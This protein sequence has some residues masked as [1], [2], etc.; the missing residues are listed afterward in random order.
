MRDTFS[1]VTYP[2]Q[3]L[4][5]LP[6]TVGGW[7]EENLATRHALQAENTS[8]RAQNL[9]LNVRLQKLATLESENMRLREL[10]DSSFKINERVLIAE[11]LAVDL[12]PFTRRIIINK[13][14]R[15]G[16]VEGQTLVDA[17]GV[18]GQ[19]VHVGPF[20]STAMLITD[21]SHAVPIQVNRNGLRAILVGTGEPDRLELMHVPN[22]ADIEVGDLLVT[23]GLGGRF[24]PGYPVARVTTFLPD[25]RERFAQVYAEPT[26]SLEQ[27]RE[28]LL[29][30]SSADADAAPGD[31]A[32][33]DTTCDAPSAQPAPAEATT[34]APAAP[35]ATN[36]AAASP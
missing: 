19:T 20:S 33:D 24:P 3:Q 35:A 9:L 8:L 13:G 32:P 11:L 21:P 10:L 6:R 27:S 36:P 4:V 7:F 31:C 5:N 34:N 29:V 26:A 25:P 17:H 16:V 12:D 23:S 2:L 1:V 22:T 14:S 18:I 28:I 15:S 30:W